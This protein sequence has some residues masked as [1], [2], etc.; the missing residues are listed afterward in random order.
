MMEEPYIFNNIVEKTDQAVSGSKTFEELIYNLEEYKIFASDYC[1][2][3][4]YELTFNYVKTPA[5]H[6]GIFFSCIR[7]KSPNMVLENSHVV[8]E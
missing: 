4:G 5:D 7:L 1:T 8:T 6:P 2:A 3:K